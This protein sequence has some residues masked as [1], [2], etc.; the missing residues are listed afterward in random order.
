MNQ[1]PDE[2]HGMNP[3]RAVSAL[4]FV[5]K[6][7]VETPDDG[8]VP[9]DLMRAGQHAWDWLHYMGHE[10]LAEA[11]VMSAGMVMEEVEQVHNLIEW[12]CTSDDD[13]V[14]PMTQERMHLEACLHAESGE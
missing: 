1:A 4:A 12:F 8:R 2:R 14:M 13:E 11:T 6:A 5:T 7:W 3:R 9:A 10:L